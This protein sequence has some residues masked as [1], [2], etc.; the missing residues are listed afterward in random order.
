MVALLVGSFV[1]MLGMAAAF[2]PQK[3]YAT[4]ATLVLDFTDDTDPEPF[5]SAGQFLVAGATGVGS[6]RQSSRATQ[7]SVPEEL[8]EP[9]PG[10][11]AALDESVLRITATGVSP[12]AVAQWANEVSEELIVDVLRRVGRS[13]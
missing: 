8:W 6:E 13:S 10:I 12:E 2:L 1:M 3:T 11:D 7:A 4:T 9:R 5:Y